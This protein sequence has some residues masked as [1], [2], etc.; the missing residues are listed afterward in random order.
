ML[1]KVVVILFNGNNSI[2]WNKIKLELIIIIILLIL[3][4]TKYS[5][6]RNNEI[7]KQFVY[8]QQNDRLFRQFLF[9]GEF[10]LKYLYTY[11]RKKILF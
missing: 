6:Y 4:K 5:Q 2:I 8:I 10:L 11:R 9:N 7:T 1:F 3:K